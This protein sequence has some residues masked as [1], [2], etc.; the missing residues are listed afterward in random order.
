VLLVDAL[1]RGGSPGSLYILE[2][3]VPTGPA[4]AV[5]MHNLDPAR[6]LHLASALGGH[7]GRLLVVGCE[8]TPL[9][10]CDEMQMGLSPV[11]RAAVDEAVPLVESLVGKLLRGDDLTPEGDNIIPRKEVTP[12]PD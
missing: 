11:V 2:P 12:C 5:E 7:A 8:P 4:P 6:V 3:D 10:A 9:D 1:P